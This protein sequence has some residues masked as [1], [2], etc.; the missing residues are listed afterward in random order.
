VSCLIKATIHH[1]I[2]P[3]NA[4]PGGLPVAVIAQ[5]LDL[6]LAILAA[7]AEKY[8]EYAKA[9][10][11]EYIH[12]PDQAYREGRGQVLRGFLGRGRLFFSEENCQLEAVARTN[13][14]AEI[15]TLGGPAA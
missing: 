12:V 15:T 1:A 6:D 14:S 5:F 8:K 7:P 11:Q 13:L 3:D 4:I 10:R 9:I 2:P